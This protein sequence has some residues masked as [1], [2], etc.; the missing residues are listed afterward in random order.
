MNGNSKPSQKMITRQ[1]VRDANERCVRELLDA[2]WPYDE[3]RESVALS[4]LARELGITRK[5]LRRVLNQ[6]HW[7]RIVVDPTQNSEIVEVR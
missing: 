6:T 3:A 5:S 1:D 4:D 2:G 7:G